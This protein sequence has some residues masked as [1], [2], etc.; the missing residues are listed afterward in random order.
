MFN[1]KRLL[2]FVVDIILIVM[3]FTLSFLLRFDFHIPHDIRQ[4][5]LQGLYV[6]IIVKPIVFITSGVYK[7]L[8]RYASLQDGIEIFKT[9]TLSS[10][11]SAFG[12]MY[13]RHFAPYPRSIFILDWI[14]L[15]SLIAA[16]RL[17]W[18]VYRETY[19]IPKTGKGHRTLIVGAGEAGSH[20]LKEI[21]RQPGSAYH[22]VGFVDDDC[23]KHGMRLNGAP[24]LGSTRHLKAI[25]RK[26][27]IE[28]VIIAVPSAGG[29]IVKSIIGACEHCHV[30]FKT[31][32]S[33]SDIIGGRITVS[34]IKDVDIEDLLGREPVALDEMAIR[35]YLTGK[36]VL[37]T[38]AAGSI[39][40]EICR[41]AAGFNPAKL[42]LF[43]NAETPLYHIEKELAVKHP[44]LRLI[45][46]IGDV[47]NISRIEALF[48]DFMPEVVFHAAAYKHVPMMEYNPV[49]AVSNNIGGTRAVADAAH[50]FGV[51]N[52][53]MISTDK[54]VNPTNVMGATKRAAE[55]YVQSLASRSETNFTTVRFGNVL[56]SNGSVIPLFREQIK[57]GGPVTVT[58][59][60][61]IRYFMTIPE[62]SQLVL[63]AGCIGNG[64][65]IFVLDMGEPVRIVDLAEEL[66]RL[67]GLLPYEDIDIVFTGLRPGEK[68]FEEL[69]IAGE[70]VRPTRHEKI[71]VV[72]AMPTD[73]GVISAMLDDLCALSKK[74]DLTGMM[75][76]LQQLVPEF[77]P[78][79]KF[80]G[81]P[82]INFKRVRPDLFPV[83]QVTH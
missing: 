43:D 58:D 53:V 16:S 60:K 62:A 79:Y 23:E 2:V 19:I 25:V 78:S 47:R 22:V 41:Q 33:I 80:D 70:G 67:S 44:E 32:P 56:G 28:E 11:L 3:S 74:S 35:S 27:R 59:P 26:H 76:L 20:L 71:R 8:W 40:S 34:Q 54:A 50:R 63:Q 48:E 68:L 30:R 9:V 82:P 36:R 73:W 24:V 46:V 64:G 65:E 17:I 57:N 45:P 75:M 13:I 37:V 49:E 52:F 66:I 29:K 12:L 55:I 21:R 69:L 31:L 81:P 42:V 4:L 1:K 61:V 38:G 14:L 10:I 5:F 77:T 15:I 6:V 7:S 51:R 39:G 18:R 83:D 72:S